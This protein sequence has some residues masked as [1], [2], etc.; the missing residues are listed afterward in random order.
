MTNAAVPTLCLKPQ[1]GI[2]NCGIAWPS[3]QGLGSPLKNQV[4]P[5]I[6]FSIPAWAEGLWG[7]E[8]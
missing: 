4:L 3:Q 7:G 2:L 1:E 5:D 8:A 6:V